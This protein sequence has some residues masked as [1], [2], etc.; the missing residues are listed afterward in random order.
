[1]H[2]AKRLVR[3]SRCISKFISDPSSRVRVTVEACKAALGGLT[4][5]MGEVKTR[6]VHGLH[7][8]IKGDLAAVRQEISEGERVDGAHGGHGVALDAGDLY[9]SAHGIAGQSQ[10]MLQRDLGGV[11]DLVD[12]HTEQLA[13]GGGGHGA[14]GAYLGLTAALC[15]ADGGIGGDEITHKPRDGKGTENMK[16]AEEERKVAQKKEETAAPKKKE[17]PAPKKKKENT[18]KK[19]EEA[20]KKKVEDNKKTQTVHQEA[21]KNDGKPIFKIQV[22]ASD[23]KLRTNDECFNGLEVECYKDNGIY[24]YTYGESD[25]YDD[26][27]K[28]KKEIADKFKGAFIIAFLNGE[29]ISTNE[30]IGLYKKQKK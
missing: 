11:L 12:A 10:V 19:K 18:K 14:G 8:H 2:P 25:S 23:R 15:P 17:E 29:R 24:K 7:H 26:I 30:A 5:E 1:M 4:V 27:V 16:K 21:K 6:A 28:Q 20:K 9:Q 22:L 13:Q 3:L